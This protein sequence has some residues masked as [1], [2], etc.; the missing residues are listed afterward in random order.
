MINMFLFILLFL[1]LKRVLRFDNVGSISF[2]ASGA[3][4]DGVMGQKNFTS[5]VVPPSVTA[6]S[7][8]VSPIVVASQYGVFIG[9]S[10][11]ARVVC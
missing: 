4:A 7:I 3:P 5:A 2:P 9:D 1:S 11:A 6:Y 10:N 8:D